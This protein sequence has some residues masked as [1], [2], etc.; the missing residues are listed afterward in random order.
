MRPD[1]FAVLRTPLLPF[2]E[3]LRLSD[4]PADRAAIEAGI[5][6]LLDR[7][8]VRDAIALASPSLAQALAER[9][10]DDT[11]L[12]RAGYRYLARMC[13][14]PTPFGLFA[15]TSLATVGRTTAL[16]LGPRRILCGWAPGRG[17]DTRFVLERADDHGIFVEIASGGPEFTLHDDGTV[18][19]D[20]P[21]QYR[22][23]A[24]RGPDPSVFV[25]SELLRTPG[26]FV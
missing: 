21:Y 14:R 7:P 1:G 25:L 19:P 15:G 20:T 17:D 16:T 18:A 3:L 10:P 11:K 2:D 9:G 13:T 24:F 22:V 12:V 26:T 5:A 6:R 8:D 4:A 23:R